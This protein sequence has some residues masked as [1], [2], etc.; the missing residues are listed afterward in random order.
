MTLLIVGISLNYLINIIFVI[1]FIKYIR[2]LLHASKQIDTISYITVVIISLCT[3]FR[4][5]FIAFSKMFPKP[6]IHIQNSSKLTPINYLCLSNII[7]DI[8][9]IISCSITLLN[10]YPLTN[11]FMLSIDLLLLIVLNT[12]I[13]IYFLSV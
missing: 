12:T 10:E 9:L 2:P 5:C 4:F 7:I 6:Y 3:N 1:I 8:I 11:P 13:T